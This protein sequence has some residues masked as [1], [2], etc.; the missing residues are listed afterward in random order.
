MLVRFIQIFSNDIDNFDGL[1]IKHFPFD[2]FGKE[3][4]EDILTS[5]E[6]KLMG[7]DD[8]LISNLLFR[9]FTADLNGL[10]TPDRISLRTLRFALKTKINSNKLQ[11]EPF[12]RLFQYLRSLT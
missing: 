12:S 9:A 3:K 7:Q 10:V 4:I 1:L 8:I 2:K 6:E 11:L 5:A